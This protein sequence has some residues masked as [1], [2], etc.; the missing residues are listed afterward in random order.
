MF[1]YLQDDFCR[2]ISF[3]DFTLE[4]LDP[5]YNKGTCIDI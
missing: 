1:I 4:E 5:L 2:G 3:D